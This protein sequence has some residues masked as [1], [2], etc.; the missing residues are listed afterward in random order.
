MPVDKAQVLLGV[1]FKSL[2]SGWLM[3][4]VLSLISRAVEKLMFFSCKNRLFANYDTGGNEFCTVDAAG[5][6]IRCFFSPCYLERLSF[7]WST[8][9]LLIGFL[10]CE[11]TTNNDYTPRVVSPLSICGPN[12]CWLLTV[13]CFH[14]PHRS[15]WKDTGVRRPN[16]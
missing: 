14:L 7:C 6:G 8:C 1:S 2:Q 12:K 13:Q 9:I 11:I 15:E 5:I 10:M 4:I 16:F 3:A